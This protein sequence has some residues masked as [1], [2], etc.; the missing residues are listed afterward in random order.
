MEATALQSSVQLD[1]L[2]QPPPPAHHTAAPGSHL[3][4]RPRAPFSPQAPPP[5]PP[6]LSDKGVSMPL[7]A[8][9]LGITCTIKQRMLW[10]ADSHP[11]ATQRLFN[12]S[13]SCEALDF[14]FCRSCHRRRISLMKPSRV[15]SDVSPPECSSTSA[16]LI[17]FTQLK[18]SAMHLL[19]CTLVD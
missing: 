11:K 9:G 18:I 14:R 8:V 7:S 17:S 13:I 15:S 5:P 1:F 6:A 12:K 10:S 4:P 19:S 2:W 16:L 3:P